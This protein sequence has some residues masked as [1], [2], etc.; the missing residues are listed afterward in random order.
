[1]R[2]FSFFFFSFCR[3]SDSS[4][5]RK[6][7]R[8]RRNSSKEKNKSP[9]RY[10]YLHHCDYS[11]GHNE[12]EIIRLTITKCFF[13]FFLYSS[14]DSSTE[15]KKDRK[16]RDSLKEINKSPE[17]YSYLHHCYYCF[18]HNKYEIIHHTVTK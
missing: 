1:M 2:Y 8:K 16:R 10:S 15:R 18:G 7:D 11:F 5:E 6:K 12:H 3:G 13:F 17:R 4:T 9:E 14:S